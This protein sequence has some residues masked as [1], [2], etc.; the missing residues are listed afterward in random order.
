MLTLLFLRLLLTVSHALL[1]KTPYM[2][3][4]T[5]RKKVRTSKLQNTEPNTKTRAESAE[6]AE[7][8]AKV[9]RVVPNIETLPFDVRRGSFVNQ[10]AVAR[11]S[12]VGAESL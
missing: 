10:L 1:T 7:E 12:S 8:N 11:S 3:D 2:K 4:E 5:E 9:S 6:V